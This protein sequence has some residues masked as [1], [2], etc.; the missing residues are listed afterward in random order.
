L[1]FSPERIDPGNQVFGLSNTPKIVGAD[2]QF[3][4]ARAIDFYKTFV[5]SV[6]ITKGTKEAETAKLLENTYR[7]VNIAL[8]NEF[9]KICHSLDIDVWEVIGAASTKPFGFQ[10]FFPGIG[11]G[12][13]CSPIDPSYLAFK[14]KEEVGEDFEFISL[15]QKISGEMPSYVANR[16][17]EAILETTGKSRINGEKIAVFGV[18]YKANSSDIRETPASD[19]VSALT[20]EGFSVCFGLASKLSISKCRVRSFLAISQIRL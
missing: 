16:V 5:P 14:L 7:Q 10:A 20:K 17:K 1:A 13:H 4:L 12:G 2:D 19:L 8:V 6:F 11:V 18:S 15:A 3:S 9:A